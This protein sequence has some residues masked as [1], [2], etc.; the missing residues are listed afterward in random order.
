MNMASKKFFLL[1]VAV[2]SMAIVIGCGPKEDE[3]PSPAEQRANL[4]PAVGDPVGAGT[5]PAEG[6]DPNLGAS[7]GSANEVGDRGG[8]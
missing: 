5:A 1:I 3:G 6:E 8:R 7:K 4:D 2:F